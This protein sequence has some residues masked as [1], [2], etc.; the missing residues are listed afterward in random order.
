[1]YRLPEN[2]TI[3]PTV[4][5]RFLGDRGSPLPNRQDFF[6]PIEAAA[7]NYPTG[8]FDMITR[9]DLR[10]QLQNATS[11]E[12]D[13]QFWENRAQ[14]LD[15]LENGT[16]VAASAPN[17]TMSGDDSINIPF[18]LG[19]RASTP[20]QSPIYNIATSAFGLGSFTVLDDVEDEISNIFP[21]NGSF[22]SFRAINDTSIA[23][24]N[25]D[26]FW[27]NSN[28]SRI[29]NRANTTIVDPPGQSLHSSSNISF[30]TTQNANNTEAS[31]RTVYFD[32]N[33]SNASLNT[34]LWDQPPE[35]E[36][37]ARRQIRNLHRPNFG[38]QS[39]LFY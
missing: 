23:S 30:N 20:I 16:P 38:I 37:R 35:E 8:S 31:H 27:Q 32:P 7:T 26:T 19:P 15:E 18:N 3:I 6:D 5:R 12:A 33:R 36:Y 28:T 39:N 14:W 9:P 4:R 1:M 22:H 25:N 10:R 21:P 11:A 29:N 2:D 34:R 17:M 13:R 24:L